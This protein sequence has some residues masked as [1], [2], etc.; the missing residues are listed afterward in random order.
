MSCP[1][2]ISE[3]A[4]VNLPQINNLKSTIHSQRKDTDLLSTPLR[5]E[6]IPVLAE[7]YHITKAGEQFLIFDSRLGDSE[8]IL[9]FAT[10][11]GI[12]FLSNNSHWFMKRTFILCQEILYQIYAIHA[13]NNNHILPCVVILLPIINE[14]TYNRLF[15]EVKDAVI[16]LGNEPTDILKDFARGSKHCYQSGTT[17]TGIES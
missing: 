3:T 1:Q 15:R 4:A 13:P 6:D 7:R 8:R 10:Q 9:I 5:R 11:Q 14:D 2:N 17:T 16:R 12:H